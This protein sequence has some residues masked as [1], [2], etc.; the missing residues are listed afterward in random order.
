M[1]D[2]TVVYYTSNREDERF[3]AKIRERLLKT[4]GDIPL[5]SVSQ[6][7][8]DFGYNICVGDVGISDQNVHRQL[9]I[10]AQHAKT[11]YVISAESDCLY[12]EAYFKYTPPII[13]G[14]FR[15][16]NLY[17]LYKD[18]GPFYRKRYSECAQICGRDFL[19]REVDKYLE[20]QPM[21]NPVKYHGHQVVGILFW[22]KN[23]TLFE[24][25]IPVL[26]VKTGNGLHPRTRIMEGWNE[27]EIPHWGTVEKMRKELFGE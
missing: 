9:Q 24:T 27:T 6:K 4:I 3:E 23:W 2:R 1:N 19:I 26:N 7:P 20:G 22:K 14:C 18:K 15:C 12:P 11:K 16:N 25:S 10:G 17:I 21:W 8:I 5:I 13:D